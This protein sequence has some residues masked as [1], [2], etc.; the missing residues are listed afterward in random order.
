[1]KVV[2]NDFACQWEEVGEDA[3]A[4]LDRVGIALRCAA[5]QR[6]ITVVQGGAWQVMGMQ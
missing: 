5:R 1:M 6:L 4:A 2:A 3:L